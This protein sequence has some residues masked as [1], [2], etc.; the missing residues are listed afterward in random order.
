MNV[1]Y[2]NSCNLWSS[3]SQWSHVSPVEPKWKEPSAFAHRKCTKRHQQQHNGNQSADAL[4]RVRITVLLGINMKWTK[5]FVA[6]F[7]LSFER[8]PLIRSNWVVASSQWNSCS[9]SFIIHCISWTLP[10][11]LL[12]DAVHYIC[13]I[14]VTEPRAVFTCVAAG[15]CHSCKVIK[16][17]CIK[18]SCV[19]CMNLGSLLRAPL[20]NQW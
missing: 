8:S 11:H 12:C 19:N 13:Y 18:M 3:C 1:R 14:T 7:H 4:V 17:A 5:I 9:S 16:Y 20:F 10:I 2:V 6:A 15:A